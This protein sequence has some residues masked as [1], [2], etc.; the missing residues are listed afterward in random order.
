MYV[1]AFVLPQSCDR[2]V[3]L[4][5]ELI[6]YNFHS[7]VLSAFLVSYASLCFMGVLICDLSGI[8]LPTFFQYLVRGGFFY[9]YSILGG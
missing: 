5:E 9:Y 3:R 4:V 8:S 6:E 7:C 1:V 2:I